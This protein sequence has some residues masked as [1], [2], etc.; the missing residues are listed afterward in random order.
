MAA[1]ISL[2]SHAL[3]S[4]YTPIKRWYLCLLPLNLD[5]RVWPP[6]PIGCGGSDTTWHLRLGHKNPTHVHL[7][8]LLHSLLESSHHVV[9]KSR[10]LQRGSQGGGTAASC[11]KPNVCPNNSQDQDQQPRPTN[12][13][14]SEPSWNAFSS[15]PL[16]PS[17]WRHLEQKQTI[18]TEPCP[19][20]RFVSKI[21]G[22]VA[23]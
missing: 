15:L 22:V 10:Q 14:M 18:P 2:V 3:S 21:N 20:Y 5:R 11:S 12:S 1:A 17:T 13:Y 16:S 4:R 6:Q 7:V 23:V 8:L 9:R 19:N